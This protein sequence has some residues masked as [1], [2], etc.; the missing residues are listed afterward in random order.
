MNMKEICKELINEI[1][2]R[3]LNAIEKMNDSLNEP[4]NSELRTDAVV[5]LCININT[6]KDQIKLV[7]QIIKDNKESE[8]VNFFVK[9]RNLY[10]LKKIR[11][12]YETTNEELLK[13]AFEHG[14]A[15]SKGDKNE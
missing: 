12:Y 1:D 4:N 15:V 5:V 14:F 13:T 8:Y 9:Q 3:T 6:N 2:N 10:W 7:N 11:R